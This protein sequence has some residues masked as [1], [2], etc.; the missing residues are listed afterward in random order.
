MAW[1]FRYFSYKGITT[2][3]PFMH[4]LD[5]TTSKKDAELV[6]LTAYQ[7]MSESLRSHIYRPYLVLCTLLSVLPL[8][9]WDCF[10]SLCNV[11]S[12]WS[13]G[14]ILTLA[15]ETEKAPTEFCRPLYQMI[16]IFV[17]FLTLCPVVRGG[18]QP[19]SK[20]IKVQE[21]R[22]CE[23]IQRQTNRSVE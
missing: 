10:S 1:L 5:S 22:Q 11:S 3:G 2:S 4:H 15:G 14:P 20:T 17:W 16:L 23:L 21:T 7:S 13:L 9:G 18:L 6:I 12:P 19:D 8:C